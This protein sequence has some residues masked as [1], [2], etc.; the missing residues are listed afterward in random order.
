RCRANLFLPCTAKQR[1]TNEGAR[2]VLHRHS[3]VRPLHKDATKWESAD[4][5]VKRGQSGAMSQS[6][7]YWRRNAQPALV[8]PASCDEVSTGPSRG[9]CRHRALFGDMAPIAVTW[10][11]VIG[12]G[13]V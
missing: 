7:R 6:D 1:R 4:L 8:R 5:N 10:N 3:R 12:T 9:D 13:F 2:D 11:R